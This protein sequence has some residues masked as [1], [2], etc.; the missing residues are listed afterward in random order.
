[1]FTL[2]SESITF[3]KLKQKWELSASNG[4]L[5]GIFTLLLT[6]FYDYVMQK[7]FSQHIL[8]VSLKAYK[9]RF[10]E[11]IRIHL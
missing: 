2:H 11:E 1:M 10:L 5:Y 9:R 7:E 4:K 3:Q 6:P 8:D